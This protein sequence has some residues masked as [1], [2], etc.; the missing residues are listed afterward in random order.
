MQNATQLSESLAAAVAACAESVV[1]VES[2]RR[3]GASGIAWAK[4]VVVTASHVLE[5]DEGLE[6]GI[7]GG[8]TA[9]ASVAG[10]DP[11]TD[12]AALRVQSAELRPI[13]WPADAPLRIGHLVLGVSRP[14]PSARARLG[15]V[16]AL[17]DS[18]RTPAGG[19][20]DRYLETDIAL[21]P[22]FSGSLL[23]D[24]AGRALGLNNA[25]LL[26]RA[27]LAIDPGTLRR[28]VGALLAH[29]AVR[30]GFLG[31]G[32]YPVRLP[33]AGEPSGHGVGLLVLSVQPGSCAAQAGLMLGD[34]LVSLDGQPLGGVADLLPFLEEERIGRTITARVL[35]A[36]EPRELSITIGTREA[37][38]APGNPGS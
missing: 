37:D 25:G 14:G 13:E 4:D 2:R 22:G 11:G 6:I 32:A 23:V 15:V 38:T 26:R 33:S 10:R 5:W 12:L 3:A 27:S 19:R 20:V 29:G 21:H 17:S 36:G 34:T 1:H 30:R 18:W 24:A 35:R 7:P 28:V 16:N 9:T 8:G 31:I